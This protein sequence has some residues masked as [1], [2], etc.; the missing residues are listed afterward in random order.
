MLCGW[1]RNYHQHEGVSA[2][3]PREK[4]RTP[5]NRASTCPRDV[6]FWAHTPL[7]E[8]ARVLRDEGLWGTLRLLGN[9]LR[10]GAARQRVIAMRSVIRRYQDRLA[11]IAIVAVK[12]D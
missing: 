10:D 11:A 12:P 4:I 6:T 1:F 9:V 3:S 7:L 8:P 2:S 5:E